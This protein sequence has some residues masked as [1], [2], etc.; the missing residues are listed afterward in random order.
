MGDLRLVAQVARFGVV[1]LA[2]DRS[3]LVFTVIFPVALLALFNAVFADEGGLAIRG[4]RVPLD[5]YFTAGMAAYALMMAAFSTL[6]ITLTSQ[7]ETGQLKRL[8][9][10][11]MPPWVFIAGQVAKVAL[12]VVAMV[13]L[14]VAIGVVA[15]GVPLS[16]AGL[17]GVAV[18]T[19]L[20]TAAFTT[21]GVAA[22]ALLRTA[23]SASAITPFATVVLGF[24]SGVWIPTQELPGWA[25]DLG[26]LFPLAHL[27]EGLQ[28]SLAGPS[29]GAGLDPLNA[30][31]LLLWGVAGLAVAA[32]GFRWTPRARAG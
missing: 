12:L 10:T 18:Y 17:A 7:R 31:V 4:A 5:G 27:A 19:L 6:A 24:V 26:Q 22:T 9:A 32:R 8:R 28:R 11:A 30:G 15:Y 29:A 13:A 20:G 23:E 25:V 16:G 2:R 3:T 1:G 14:L 21:L